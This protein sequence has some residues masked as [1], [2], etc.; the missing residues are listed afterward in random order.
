MAKDPQKKKLFRVAVGAQPADRAISTLRPDLR[1]SPQLFYGKLCFVIKDPVT[2]RYFR[3]QPVEHFLTQQMDGKRTARDLL[4]LLQ[5]QFPESPLTVQDVLRFVGMLHESHLLVGEGVAHSE[6]LGAQSGKSRRRRW[7]QM[8][9]NFLFFR[10]PLFNPDRLLTHLDALVGNLIFRPFTIIMSGIL[11]IAAIVGLL[12]H[13][14]KLFHT[15]YSLLSWQNLLVLYCVFIVTKVFH[16]FG[17]G[18]TTKHFG[19]EVSQM[20]VIVMVFTPSFYCDTSDAWMI[21]SRAA[22]LW[23]NSGGVL[24]ELVLASLA[25]FVWIATRSHSI[26]NQISLNIMISCSVATLFFNG[27]PLMRYDGYYFLADLLEIPNLM[28]KGREFLKYYIQKYVLNL[29]PD[30]PPDSDR[31]V[32]LA[33]YTVASTAYRWLVMFAIIMV[34]YV[35]FNHY[36]VAFIGVLLAAGY[37]FLSVLLPLIKACRFLWKQRW[38]V[39]KRVRWV[40]G[41]ALAGVA[42]LV[43]V[44]FIPWHMTI[45]EPLVVLAREDQPVFVQS[46]GYVLRVYKDVGQYVKKGGRIVKLVDR[47]LEGRLDKAQAMAQE[48]QIKSAQAM[49]K[50]NSVAMKMLDEELNAYDRQIKLLKQRERDLVIRAPISGVIIRRS[51]LRH[52]V[53][54]YVVP[55][56]Q[57][58]NVMNP[59]DMQARVS[60]PQ[61]LAAMVHP[62]MPVTMRLW[63]QASHA[64]RFHVNRVS[65]TLSDQLLHPALAS[66]DKG[67]LA[68][69]AGRHG[70]MRTLDRRSTVIINL[71]NSTRGEFLADGMTGRAE[72]TV[73]KTTVIGR[74]WRLFLDTTTPDLRL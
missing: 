26:V 51:S 16:E 1:I 21:P 23:I 60:L 25:T 71:G 59:H 70:G 44:A 49:A 24:V 43:G 27:N 20:G 9:Q 50:N 31:L 61:Q 11:L 22:R 63:A 54:N 13:T 15:P 37:I 4:G 55:S 28:T 53:G 46:P 67:D 14:D 57:L 42:L 38:D 74:V 39:G 17:H 40:G 7:I 68:V 34:L 52:I 29:K 3:L 10:M 35:F 19:G 18:M 58:C 36:G 5:Q 2:L 56:T 47:G 8:A 6:W 64:L 62:G 65:S 30:L 48:L 33:I 66:S 45:R 73:E 12:G 32:P 41:A 69:R 72:I